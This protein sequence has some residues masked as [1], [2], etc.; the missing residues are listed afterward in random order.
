MKV[1][2]LGCGAE[3]ELTDDTEH[4]QCPEC[5]TVCEKPK[6]EDPTNMELKHLNLKWNK[7]AFTEDAEFYHF[8]GYAST[9]GNED[10]GGDVVLPGCFLASLKTRMPKLCEQHDI[11][12]PRGVFDFVQEDEKGLY[13][14]G[15]IPKGNSK[16]NDLA[17]LVKCGAIDSMSIG[18]TTDECEIDAKNNIRYLKAVTLYEIS[19]VT[20]PMNERA[21]IDEIKSAI[22]F[23]NLPLADKDV[24][25]DSTKAI[26]RMRKFCGA[27]DAPNE[28]YKK[29]F[30]WV[31]DEN[32]DTFGAYKLPIADIVDGSMKAIP[33]AIFAAASVLQ[34]GRGG[35][36]I[37]EVDKT[38]IKAHIS[39]YYKKLDMVA[40]WDS[41]NGKSQDLIDSIENMK[42]VNEFL[43]SKGLSNIE[44]TGIIAKIKQIKEDRNGESEEIIPCNTEELKSLSSGLSAL[45]NVI[46]NF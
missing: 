12:S 39:K 18:F 31:D 43:R 21:K 4:V 7:K 28:K 10:L 41:D 32:S 19:F 38:K 8:K 27:E 35:V 16:C 44:R 1:K 17:V 15:R 30:C 45:K 46:Q 13:V 36:N 3:I 14:E 25:W 42:D 29:A 24:A 22:P 6:N 40:P 26:G 34:G 37:P 2:C 33:R 11:R 9:F 20:L 5:D 23:Q